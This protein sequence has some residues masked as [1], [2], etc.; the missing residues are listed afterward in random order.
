MLM[1]FCKY[2]TQYLA[3]VYPENLLA[4]Q[5]SSLKILSARIEF[6]INIW[7]EPAIICE[8]KVMQ[9][10]EFLHIWCVILSLKLEK[11][12]MG[13]Q[14]IE[15]IQIWWYCKPSIVGKVAEQASLCKP[16]S[17]VLENKIFALKIFSH[18]IQP[19]PI[20]YTFLLISI[21]FS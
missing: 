2:Y 20:L 16:P 12:V 19:L 1:I 10:L 13:R 6:L 8:T 4:N 3:H 15:L 7:W 17:M 18:L 14:I 11:V 21:C 5:V 9:A